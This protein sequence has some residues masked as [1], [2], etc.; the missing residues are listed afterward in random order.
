MSTSSTIQTYVQICKY[1]KRTGCIVPS[2][3]L[4]LHRDSHSRNILRIVLIDSARNIERINV[5]NPMRAERIPQ[6]VDCIPVRINEG[7]RDSLFEIPRLSVSDVPVD[8][9]TQG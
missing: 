4:Y 8:C 1:K 7:G 2:V 3:L 9:L 6:S 5:P